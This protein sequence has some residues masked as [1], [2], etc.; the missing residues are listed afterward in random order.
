VTVLLS[1]TKIQPMIV[2][3]HIIAFRLFLIGN[4]S[5]K[6]DRHHRTGFNASLLAS[7]A[8]LLIPIRSVEA[9]IAF[10]GFSFAVDDRP[11]GPVRLLRTHFDAGFAADAFLAVNP[12]NVAVCGVHEG[13]SG[14]T[15]LNT[16]WRLTLAAGRHLDVVGEFG[17]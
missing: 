10:G 14:W 7:R 2:Q 15:A 5:D 4:L 13:C 16:D 17:E 1:Q 12:S 3:I 8:S 11:D 6:P 9:Q